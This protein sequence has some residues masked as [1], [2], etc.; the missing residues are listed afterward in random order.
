MGT[1]TSVDRS[2]RRQTHAPVFLSTQTRPKWLLSSRAAE[3]LLVGL[4]AL[5]LGF[6][7]LTLNGLGNTYYAAADIT[8]SGSLRALFFATFDRGGVMAVDKPPLGLVGPAFA[9]RLF[10]TSSWTVLGPQVV[11]FAG[12]LVVFFC[13]LRR[14]TNRRVAWIGALILLLTPIDV[15]VARSN[16]PDELLVFFTIL[17]LVMVGESMRDARF[18]LALAAGAA[19]GLAFTTKQLQALVAV[20]A[21]VVAIAMLSAGGWRRRAARTTVFLTSSV[22]TSAAWLWAVDRIAQSQRPYVSNARNNSEFN[23]AFGFNGAHRVGQLR[24]QPSWVPVGRGWTSTAGRLIARLIPQRSL[25]AN[26]Y[27]AQTSWLLMVALVGGLA[28][29]L[30]RRAD[31]PKLVRFLLCW[32]SFHALVLAYAPGKFSPYYVAPLVP[33]IAA[34]VA[35]AVDTFGPGR[36]PRSNSNRH[37]QPFWKRYSDRSVVV[38]MLSALFIVAVAA[39]SYIGFAN[40]VL[41]CVLVVVAIC[42]NASCAPRRTRGRAVRFATF[43]TTLLAFTAIPGRYVLADVTSRQNAVVPNAEIATGAYPPKVPAA[44]DV[45]DTRI[46]SFVQASSVPTLATSRISSAAGGIIKGIRVVP[47]GGFFGTD[48]YPTLSTFTSMITQSRVRWVAVPALPPGRHARSLPPAMVARPWGPWVRN[49][50]RL[51]APGEYGG[52]DAGKYWVTNNR[53]PLHAPLALYDC[54]TTMPSRNPFKTSQ[55]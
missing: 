12:G 53:I 29:V 3:P 16:N 41:G 13:G 24:H 11:L 39:R 51:V 26:H 40:T 30:T 1:A 44:I 36:L 5:V 20:P 31:Q 54:R 2:V 28:L 38:L 8:G 23:L 55:R 33:G 52:V 46:V 43:A 14:W 7:R 25:L 6:W 35:I 21:L 48:A 10:G 34:L 47:L 22:L 4:A 27:V 9:V 32:T 19:V 18:R 15:A 49:H 42:L 17:S 37:S 50:C 45:N